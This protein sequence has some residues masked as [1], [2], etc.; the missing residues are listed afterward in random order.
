MKSTGVT[1]TRQQRE[2]LIYRW[3]ERPSEIMS[4]SDIPL[5]A[6]GQKVKYPLEWMGLGA[7]FFVASNGRS[8]EQ[9][10]NSVNKSVGLVR[11]R[12]GKQF[13]QHRYGGRGVRVWRIA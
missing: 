13:Y 8:T 12:T 4:K 9:V 7:H 1:L 11:R 10:N 5:G 6:R 2:M 3:V